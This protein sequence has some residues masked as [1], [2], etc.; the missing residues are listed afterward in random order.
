[1]LYR[2]VPW[3]LLLPVARAASRRRRRLHRKMCG[4]LMRI[5]VETPL[6]RSNAGFSAVGS[7]S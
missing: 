5:V 4:L 2:A 6:C 1:M 7:E 3:A